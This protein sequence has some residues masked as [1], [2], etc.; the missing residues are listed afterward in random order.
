MSDITVRERELEREKEEWEQGK[1]DRKRDKVRLENLITSLKDK[2]LRLEEA[3]EPASRFLDE[4]QQQVMVHSDKIQDLTTYKTALLKEIR[5]A[6]AEMD[7]IHAKTTEAHEG[8]RLTLS[9]LEATIALETE[10]Q[11]AEQ[12]KQVE[13]LNSQL[14]TARTELSDMQIQQQELMDTHSQLTDD[15]LHKEAE[16]RKRIDA[17]TE[18]CEVFEARKQHTEDELSSLQAHHQA[19]TVANADLTKQN[20]LFVEYENKAWKVLNAKDESLQQR[21]SALA[22]KEQLRPRASLLPPLES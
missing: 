13:L 11:K 10:N 15:L 21:E 2:R 6:Q 14:L 18:A 8:Q 7:N 19:L 9:T 3:V 17:A 5:T 4:L 22:E 20:A 1:S 12:A 16:L